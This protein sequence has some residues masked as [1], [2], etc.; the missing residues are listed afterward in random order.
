MLIFSSGF[1]ITE[2][3]AAEGPNTEIETKAENSRVAQL[4]Q[5]NQQFAATVVI[6]TY[7]TLAE[8]TSRLAL[9]SVT[10]ENTPTEANL[11]NLRDAW[12]AVELTWAQSNAFEFGPVHSLGYGPAIASPVD[13][14]GL[15]LLLNQLSENQ[16]SENQ[17]SENQ[18][19]ETEGSAAL[20]NYLTEGSIH[21]SLKGLEAIAHLLYHPEKTPESGNRLAS[22]F[23]T[24]ERTYLNYLA[25]EVQTATTDLLEVWQT[26]W[27]NYPAYATVLA[28][29]GS[30]DNAVYIST[31]SGTEEIIRGLFN[32]LDVVV[33]EELPGLIAAPEQLAESALDLQLLN[34][35]LM[36]IQLASRSTGFSELVNSSSDQSQQQIQQS[37]ETATVLIAAAQEPQDP[38][39]ISFALTV[40]LDSLQTAHAL[41][42]SD[43]L[44]LAQE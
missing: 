21:P 37:L 9:A 16:L 2:G 22:D 1:V 3:Q 8:Q 5:I 25:A 23:S 43:V 11:S 35:T 30:P 18:L 4:Q 31:R 12:L 24:T 10:F 41:I 39:V 34:S 15:D 36:G 44:P 13:T 27:N 28:N 14:T 17:L 7:Q 29:A 38:D 33:N 26:G 32:S 20:A 6:P 42:D 19:S 40:A